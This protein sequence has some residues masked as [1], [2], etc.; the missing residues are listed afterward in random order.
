MVQE[1]KVSEDYCRSDIIVVDLNNYSL[2]HLL[3]FSVPYVKKLELCVLVSTVVIR[4]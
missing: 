1:I 2:D 3:K 4:D